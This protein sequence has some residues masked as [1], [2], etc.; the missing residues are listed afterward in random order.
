[1]LAAVSF[2]KT[3]TRQNAT[4]QIFISTAGTSAIYCSA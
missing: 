3:G 4:K 1:M 2:S